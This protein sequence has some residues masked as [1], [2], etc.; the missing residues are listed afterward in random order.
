MTERCEKALKPSSDGLAIGPS[1]VIWEGS[2][3]RIEID[4]KAPLT[5]APLR[6]TVTLEPEILPDFVADFGTTAAIAG[7]PLRRAP[8]S[9]SGSIARRLP[10]TA[11]AIWT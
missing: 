6:G 7:H 11:R 3:L 9:K 4:E 8:M 5:M 2:R 1:A 10:G